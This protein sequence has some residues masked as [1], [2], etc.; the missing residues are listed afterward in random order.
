M[1]DQLGFEV[2]RY[3]FGRAAE[4]RRQMEQ[5]AQVREAST[6]LREVD[7]PTELLTVATRAQEDNT[8]N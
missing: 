4:V 7:D 6:L 5:D 1:R 3:I 2:T 8:Q